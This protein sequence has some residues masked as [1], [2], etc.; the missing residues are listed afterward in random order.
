MYVS[1]KFQA[2]SARKRLKPEPDFVRHKS[3]RR[4]HRERGN[5]MATRMGLCKAR[6]SCNSD[7]FRLDFVVGKRRSSQHWRVSRLAA[8]AAHR[9]ALESSCPGAQD[10]RLSTSSSLELDPQHLGNCFALTSKATGHHGLLCSTS[11][12]T[13]NACRCSLFPSMSRQSLCD[14][15]N[16]RHF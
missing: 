3:E 5:K 10:I 12:L 4:V 13:N 15:L 7:R 1:P 2:Q 16:S 9:V 14:A 11:L 8:L 6:T